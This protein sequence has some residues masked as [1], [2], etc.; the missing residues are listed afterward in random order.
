MSIAEHPILFSTEMVRAILE[1]RKTQTRLIIKESYNGCLTNGG[2]HPCPNEPV[3]MYPGEV[4]QSPIEGEPDMVITGNKVHA[5]FFCSTMD[6]TAYC[7]FGKPGDW[8]WVRETWGIFAGMEESNPIIYRAD[9]NWEASGINGPVHVEGNRWKPCIH[10][11]KEHSRIWL[12]VTDITVEALQDISD[13]DAIDEGVEWRVMG[14]E[15]G[16]LEGQRL[17]KD[18]LNPTNTQ[19]GPI[20]AKDSFQYLWQSVNGNWDENPWVWVI[21]FNVLSTTG[22]PE[23][24]KELTT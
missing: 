18:Y 12:Q 14:K 17:Y 5:N 6:R 3:V 23:L 8:L 9:G 19:F 21:K 13:E 22:R 11:K 7:R 20:F 4:I 24:L 1:G 15:Y 2:P 10:L 16:K